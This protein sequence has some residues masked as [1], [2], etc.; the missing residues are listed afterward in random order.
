[1][2]TDDD[3]SD[4]TTSTTTAQPEGPS[5]HYLVVFKKGNRASSVA[6]E[7]KRTRKVKVQ[8]VLSHAVTAYE[9]D[10]P[11]DE[12]DDVR[13]DPRV[14]YVAEPKPIERFAQTLPWGVEQRVA[15]RQRLELHPSR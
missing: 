14:A 1:M 4:D 15:H 7:H 9:A 12:I 8:R 10:I 5:K 3:A 11:D 13:N 6:D 2:E